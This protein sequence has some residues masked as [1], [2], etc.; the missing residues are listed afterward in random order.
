MARSEAPSEPQHQHDVT[1]ETPLLIAGH[2]APDGDTEA[3]AMIGTTNSDMAKP[4]AED[5][6][7]PIMQILLLCY[8]RM[9]EPIAFFSIFPFIAQM[10]Q[11]NGNIPASDVGF[12]SGIIESIFSA[13]QMLVLIFWNRLAD[14]V[15]RKPVLVLSLCGMAVSPALFCMA[16]TLPQMIMFRCIAGVFSGSSLIIRTMIADHCTP[17]TQ[18]RAFS[19]FAFGGNVGIFIGP[20]I[21]GALADPVTQYPRAFK[22]IVFFEKYPY[23][24]S[25][26]VVGI[27]SLTGAIVSGLFLK[28]TLPKH[29]GSPG[30]GHQTPPRP[31]TWQLLKAPGVG[32]VL[33]LYSHVMLLAFAFTAIMPVALYTPVRLGGLGFGP[34]LISAYMAV[35]GASQALWLLFAFPWL[36]NRFGNRR[37]LEFCAI[38]YPFFFAGY[39][40]LNTLLRNGS[41]TAIVWFWTIGAF[42]AVVGPGV[43]MAFT[44]VQLA[45]N[46][47]SPDLFIMGNLNALALTASS[48]IRSIAPGVAT[49]IYAVG[50]R[51]QILGGHLAWVLLIPLSMVFT[52]AARW[53]PEREKPEQ[54]TGDADDAA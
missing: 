9:M 21:G 52:V 16:Q 18:A 11:R 51:D 48:G 39:I 40:V 7:L 54:S 43:S 27:I 31:S 49:A 5:K 30:S 12:Y 33:W 10:V 6:P 34:S 44:G 47:I 17:K 8:A 24:L 20:I 28:E 1:E 4:N 35:Q 32:F 53:T 23:A 13:T 19:W 3:S 25:G 41:H 38:A 29:N 22:G 36:H 50:V 46:D 45:I 26:Y 2:I 37:V 15:G 14:R 42:V